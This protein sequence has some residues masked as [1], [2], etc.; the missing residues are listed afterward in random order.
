MSF[1]FSFLPS[2][3][4]PPPLSLPCLSLL[5]A[6][7]ITSLS[8]LNDHVLRWGSVLSQQCHGEAL[9]LGVGEVRGGHFGEEKDGE[10]KDSERGVPVGLSV[11][12]LFSSKRLHFPRGKGSRLLA[13]ERRVES[14]FSGRDRRIDDTERGFR[15]EK[16]AK[17]GG[18]EKSLLQ[19]RS[20]EAI[21]REQAEKKIKVIKAPLFFFFFAVNKQG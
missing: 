4:C 7:S 11:L 3:V 8:Y 18:N 9:A 15:E 6:R 10:S 12:F 14:F 20:E 5:R 2:I 1:F 16:N 17:K 21:E 19:E 13:R